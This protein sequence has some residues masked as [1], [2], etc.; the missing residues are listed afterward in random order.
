LTQ[1]DL[2]ESAP[3]WRHW[4]FSRRTFDSIST[5]DWLAFLRFYRVLRIRIPY[6]EPGSPELDGSR[7]HGCSYGLSRKDARDVLFE[8]AREIDWHEYLWSK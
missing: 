2:D 5:Q 6:A 3:E 4:G 7:E 8:W 1:I